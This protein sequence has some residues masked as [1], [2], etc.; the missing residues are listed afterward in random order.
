LQDAILA[1]KAEVALVAP[2]VSGVLASDGS[3]VPAQFMIDGGPSVLFDAVALLPSAEAI[4]DLV[5][6][7]AVRD[8]IADAFQHCK[9]IGYVADAVP[10]MQV[11]GIADKLDEGTVELPGES[12]SS[13]IGELGKL[14]V[15]AREPSVKLGKAS[16]PP[17]K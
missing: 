15:W 8:F 12:L 1:E 4:D 13:F 9:F 11:A 6:E 10:L 2:K 16:P 5:K 3:L 17:A 14:R 7:A